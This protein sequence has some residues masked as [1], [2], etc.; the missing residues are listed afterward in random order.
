MTNHPSCL[1]KV[2]PARV[3]EG[4]RVYA[5]G[6][7]HGRLDLLLRLMEQ[8]AQ[9][10]EQAL[11]EGL[12]PRRLVLVFLGDYI[13]RGDDSRAVIDLLAGGTL[14]A[15]PLAGAQQVC[16][17]GNHE[18]YLLQFLADFS[19]APAWF[20]NGG[21]EAVRSYLGH[22][23]EGFG[24]DFPALQR[25]LYRSL[26]PSHLRFLSRLPLRHIEGDYL[27]AHA[28]IRPGVPIE[29]Q[30]AFDLMWIRE[31]FLSTH[32]PLDKVVVHGH[33]GVAEPEI[34]PHRIAIDTG[35]YRSGRLTCL[36]LDGAGRR[37]LAT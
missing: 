12:A 35:A 22:L 23:P 34:H 14:A 2:D 11:A 15:G 17:R 4:T 10:A 37:F 3:P 30:D 5:I 8:I 6:D 16:L 33:T 28:G 19:V 36:V 13:D 26:P 27:F 1:P 32:Q 20:R 9:D 7:I 25:R 21:L 31:P 24:T 29:R 18:D